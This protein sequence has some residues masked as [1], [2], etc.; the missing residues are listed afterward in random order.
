MA[1]LIGLASG[2]AF[3]WLHLPLPWTLGSLFAAALTSILGDGRWLMPGAARVLAR[4]VVGIIAGSA[5]TPEIA[6][7]ALQWWDS[8]LAVFAF[9]VVTTI[10]GNIFFRKFGR[11]DPTTALFAS[12]PG[13]LGELTLLGG[14]LG[15]DMRRLILVHVVRIIITVVSIPVFFQILL[16]HPIGR[17]PLFAT[18]PH[19]L[20]VEDI[21]VLGLCGLAAYVLSRVLRFPPGLMIFALIFSA[22]VHASGITHAVLPPW[23]TALMQVVVGSIAG[24]RFSGI[25]WFE[26]R[27]TLVAAVVWAA[28]LMVLAGMTAA[29]T[30][31]W[32]DRPFQAM[33][34]ALAPGGMVEMTIITFALGIDVAFVVTCQVFRIAIVV[35]LMPFCYRLFGVGPAGTADKK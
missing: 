15:G 29:V 18:A 28:T 23:A 34:L 32:F 27:T 19:P 12:A 10:L 9:S 35:T 1:L 11:F 22:V 26:I 5:F 21:G 4:P 3:Y 6:A 30:S 33:L 24:S 31:L 20:S 14:M 13:G 2:L 7:A 16:G 25:R 17:T 8:L